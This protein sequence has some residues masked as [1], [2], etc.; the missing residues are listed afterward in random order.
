MRLDTSMSSV[1][2]PVG[3]G[4]RRSCL[5]AS[6]ARAEA[7]LLAR[8]ELD[9]TVVAP[10]FAA[11]PVADEKQL[12]GIVTPLHREQPRVVRTPVFGLPVRLEIVALGDIG[13]ALR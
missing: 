10:A 12:V 3:H 7:R 8:R 6:L 9:K 13:S 4:R 11:D 1:A 5:A 2:T